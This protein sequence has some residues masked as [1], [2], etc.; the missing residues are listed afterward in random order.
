[1][2]SGGGKVGG[3]GYFDNGVQH[4]YV[5]ALVDAEADAFADPDLFAA[6]VE[7]VVVAFGGVGVGVV[8]AFGGVGVGVVEGLDE[9]VAFVYGFGAEDAAVYFCVAL[10]VL[11]LKDCSPVYG[12]VAQATSC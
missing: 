4:H 1:M 9:G 10:A 2:D 6:E 3:A 5:V 12:V 7:A 8:V 11:A